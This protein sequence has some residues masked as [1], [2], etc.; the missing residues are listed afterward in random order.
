[1]AR[2]AGMA[3]LVGRRMP[4]VRARRRQ[5][6]RPERTARPSANQRGVVPAA[7]AI[8]VSG[9]A[10]ESRTT[11]ANNWIRPPTGRAV[12]VA[13]AVGLDPRSG[14]GAGRDGGVEVRIPACLAVRFRSRR[15]CIRPRYR[16][17]RGRTTGSD[18]PQYG[19]LRNHHA[20]MS[21]PRQIPIR[22][23][24]RECRWQARRTWSS[25]PR[26]AD[27]LLAR[28]WSAPDRHAAWTC[29]SSADAARIA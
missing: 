7:R 14:S 11:E 5:A 16:P 23:P 3:G 13:R 24:H 26:L 4:L 2:M 28:R 15:S 1:M 22:S 27:R 8:F 20:K 6:V 18:G 19:G 17:G 21:L 25:C 12:V 29:R 9:Q 10:E